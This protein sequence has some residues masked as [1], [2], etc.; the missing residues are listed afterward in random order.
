MPIKIKPSKKYIWLLQTISSS[1]SRIHT[2]NHLSTVK[3]YR[4]NLR[5]IIWSHLLIHRLQPRS[6]EVS[7]FKS[8]FKFKYLLITSS[9][10]L[11]TSSRSSKSVLV[12][13]WEL[14]FF[15]HWRRE[16]S[17][18]VFVNTIIGKRTKILHKSL[19]IRQYLSPSL[20]RESYHKDY[21]QNSPHDHLHTLYDP[22]PQSLWCCLVSADLTVKERSFA[23]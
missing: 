4:R 19:V 13:D 9:N 11:R 1:S 10:R 3:S 6:L 14:D 21:P 2:S 20:A 8:S 17:I 16:S 7:Y 23:T 5:S 22:F 12:I 18:V 15:F